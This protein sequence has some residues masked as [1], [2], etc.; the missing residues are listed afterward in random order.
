M[1]LRHGTPG[2]GMKCINQELIILTNKGCVLFIKW[3]VYPII[4]HKIDFS[5]ER[6]C[7]LGWLVGGSIHYDTLDF[8]KEL[9]TCG[10]Y[11]WAFQ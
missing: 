6:T 5:K 10:L 11:T 1:S 3:S 7:Q 4:L 9:E 8:P 2:I